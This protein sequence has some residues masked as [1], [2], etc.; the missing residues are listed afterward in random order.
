M[1]VMNMMN[2]MDVMDVMKTSPGVSP[3]DATRAAHRP[4]CCR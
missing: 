3:A 2:L 4:T 1:D